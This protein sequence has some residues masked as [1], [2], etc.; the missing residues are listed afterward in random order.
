MQKNQ[1]SRRQL[2]KLGALAGTGAALAA[3]AAP[4]TPT[5]APAA[6]AEP[7]APAATEA[8]AAPAATEAPAAPAP[9]EAP[10][11]PAASG[12]TEVPRNRTLVV[13]NGT[14]QVG[15]MNPWTA[16]YSHQQGNALLWEPL[17]YFSLFAD[18]ELPWLA[19]SG[20]YNADFTEL[21]IKIRKGAEWSDGTP[22]TADDVK[23]T[24]DGQKGN[25]KLNYHTQVDRYV[26][27]VKVVD[28]STA[29]ISF[30]APSPRFKF[31]ILSLKFDT[32][33]PM[34][35]A[36][37]LSKEA[38]VTA[39]KGADVDGNGAVTKSMPNS[40]PYK[41]VNWTVDQKIYDLRDDWWGAKSGFSPLAQARRVIFLQNK[42]M[43]ATAQRVVL[44]ETD[45]SLDLRTELIKSTLAQNPKIT[46]HTG[47]NAPHG[48]LDWWPN[49]LWMNHEIQPY[50]DPKFRRAISLMVD[51]A[52]LNEV[53]FDGAN[54]ATIYPFPLYPGL[55]KFADS[56]PVKALEEKYTP[57]K[58]DLAE[59]EK[60][61][62]E[63]GYTKNGDGLWEKDG[64]TISG[65]INGFESIHADIVPV[66][67]EMLRA[68]G[69]D[70]SINFGPDGYQN[71]AD[72]KPGF[73]MFGHGA[74]L[75][76]P[77]AVF[78]LWTIKPRGN[79]AGSNN[80]SR[81]N[82]AEF[83]KLV[84]TMAPLATEDPKFQEAAIAAMEIYWRDLID[85]P[86][87]QWLHRIPMNQTYWTNWPTEQ[88]PYLNGAFWH[89]TFPVMAIQLK[90]AQ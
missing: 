42:E 84:E 1:L 31:E 41:I 63:L 53:L 9:T 30:S 21:T 55:Q 23:F 12:S 37:V 73:Y 22:V 76:D 58:Y 11:A 90:P 46:T 13:Q 16:G 7:A 10:A 4:A 62:G 32:G 24:L 15:L 83:D 60:L 86:L 52:K 81:F 48:Y 79:T 26:K 38:D 59:A 69:I 27:E 57:G 19:E 51:R 25:D 43:Q 17:F 64:A 61:I 45:A 47:N 8:P 36:H 68:G 49:S 75:V 34:V 33:I 71:M 44:N 67:V 14:D 56:A 74:S 66:V 5:A 82:N 70:A 39:F 65:V 2:L 18:K 80:F 89:H 35:P 85:V 3:C 54:V 77:F 20:T 29:V 28:P 78:E 40:G 50:G 72:G 87:I 6:P 88:N